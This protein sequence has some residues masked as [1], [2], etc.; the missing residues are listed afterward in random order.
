MLAVQDVEEL[1]VLGVRGC[2]K[3]MASIM[4]P[5]A[6]MYG[7]EPT[8]PGYVAVFVTQREAPLQ[9]LVRLMHVYYP[10]CGAYW[11][12]Q[13]R[14]WTFP[15]GEVVRLVCLATESAVDQ[16][17]RGDNWRLLVVDEAST[18]EKPAALEAML[19]CAR[20]APGVPCRIVWLS[21]S[22]GKNTKWVRQRFAPPGTVPGVP[23]EIERPSI[24]NADDGGHYRPW[25]GANKRL[26]ICC[27][28]GMNPHLDPNYYA[29]FADPTVPLARALAAAAAMWQEGGVG[30]ALADILPATIAVSDKGLPGGKICR[31][32]DP[33]FGDPAAV[34][35][36]LL[37][38]GS[39]S[40]TIDCPSGSY[41]VGKQGDLLVLDDLWLGDPGTSK[42][43]QLTPAALTEAIA[44]AERRLAYQ[45][46]IQSGPLDQYTEQAVFRRFCTP[47]GIRWQPVRKRKI[48]GKGF[49]A[50]TF[51][52]LRGDLAAG[53]MRQ[54]GPQPE[55]SE[56][57]E[58]QQRLAGKPAVFLRDSCAKLQEE[59]S[60]LQLADSGDDVADGQ[61]DHLFDALRYLH[62]FGGRGGVLEV[63]GIG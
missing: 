51:Q 28:A 16:K 52:A 7:P 46:D 38:D 48:A 37:C 22:Y 24:V 8:G 33:G 47:L 62:S 6:D 18:W 56:F 5:L 26:L 60:E 20:A 53:L 63:R 41:E 32:A 27:S 35:W 45:P 40:I 1:C 30:S 25:P 9:S 3:T 43:L 59:L 13:H 54:L 58:V 44:E 2:G 23:F 10:R 29:Q 11:T 31:A 50:A 12:S 19:T 36:G 21:N 15:T 61:S 17:V 55:G 42:G 4:L 14:E 57:R 34:V 39:R 49:R